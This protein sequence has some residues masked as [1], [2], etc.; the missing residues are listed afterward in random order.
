MPQGS[1]FELP[2]G[3][4]VWRLGWQAG[5]WYVKS[6]HKTWSR[7]IFPQFRDKNTQLPYPN[8]L[9]MCDGP[10]GAMHPYSSVSKQSRMHVPRANL[11]EEVGLHYETYRREA[12]AHHLNMKIR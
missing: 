7:E 2:Q 9:A 1:A 11:E 10:Y 6:I 3:P 4:P 12:K 8:R 5:M